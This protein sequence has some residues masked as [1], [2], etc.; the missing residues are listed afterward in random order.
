MNWTD[1]ALS[2]CFQ[3]HSGVG[4]GGGGSVVLTTPLLCYAA[5]KS[6]LEV[7]VY[8]FGGGD[9]DVIGISSGFIWRKW[10]M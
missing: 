5:F 7:C 2:Q 6:S 1:V 8:V 4:G 3:R 10:T 9:Y